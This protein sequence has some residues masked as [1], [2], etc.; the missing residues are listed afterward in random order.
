MLGVWAIVFLLVSIA[1]RR[2]QSVP[3]HNAEAEA[4]EITPRGGLTSDEEARIAVF[5][6][7]SPSVVFIT[8]FE[9][10]SRFFSLNA[11]EIPKGSGSGFVWDD[12]GHVVTNYH[13]IAGADRIYVTLADHSSWPARVVGF[14]PDKDIAVLKIERPAEKL[15]PIAVGTSNDLNVGQTVLAIGNPFGLDQTLTVGVV[16]ALGR[17]IE[18]M[19]GRKIRDVIQTDAAINPG[20]SGG[21]LLDSAGRLIGVNTQIASPSGSSVGIGFAVPVNT[22]NEI[23]TDII[24]YGRVRRP[25]LGILFVE[26][27]LTRRLGYRGCLIDMVRKN[28]GAYIADFLGTIVDERGYI[29]RLGDIIVK[30]DDE[31]VWTTVELKDALDRYQAGDEVKVLYVRDGKT[32]TASVTL[33]LIE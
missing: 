3:L 29:H 31:E 25:G 26:D 12:D 14:E 16:S 13:V 4:R 2:T 10:A 27:W 21:P 28:G 5:R 33:Q 24:R 1:L 18:S 7:V 9:Y 30:I 22:I 15:K 6:E 8:P 32:F 23:V 20:N 17:E 19:N 11:L